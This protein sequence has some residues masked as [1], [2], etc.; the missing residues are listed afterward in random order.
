MVD[1]GNEW[2]DMIRKSISSGIFIWEDGVKHWRVKSK[3]IRRLFSLQSGRRDLNLNRTV[4]VE[5]RGQILQCLVIKY[6][7]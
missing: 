1:K 5:S 6:M 7:R 3:I 2:N 4:G